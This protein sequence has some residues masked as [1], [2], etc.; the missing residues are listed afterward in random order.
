MDVAELCTLSTLPLHSPVP[1]GCGCQNVHLCCWGN[2]H[3]DSRAEGLIHK[4]CYPSSPLGT[5][6]SR[7]RDVLLAH[8]CEMPT[9]KRQNPEGVRN[10]L[11]FSPAPGLI[12]HKF[13]SQAVDYT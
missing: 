8:T 6:V 2:L 1:G 11:S 4:S 9:A 12:C 3:S 5:L 7:Q 13:V 10:L